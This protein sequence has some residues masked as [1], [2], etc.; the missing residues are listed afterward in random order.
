MRGKQ[1]SR[2]ACRNLSANQRS[3][4][5]R[6]ADLTPFKIGISEQ[7][8]TALALWMAKDAGCYAAGGLDAEIV[9]MGGGSRGAAAL[10]AG[11]I[12]AMHVGLSS[13]VRVNQASDDLRIIAALANVIR[14]TLFSAPDM[15][16]TASLKGGAIGISTFGSESESVAVLALRRLGLSRADVVLK[17]LGGGGR[18]LEALQY[19]SIKATALNEPVATLA[20]ERGLRVMLDLVPERIPWLFTGIVVTRAAIASRRDLLTRFLSATQEG[21][22]IALTD[23]ERAKAVLAKEAGIADRRVLDIAYEDFRALSPPDLAPTEA[24]AAN[25]LAHLP[26]AGRDPGAYIDGGI[27]K[28][29][30]R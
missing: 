29:L 23:P 28:M 10:A 27:L 24:A 13:V 1:S 3:R 25:V 22:R 15:T 5:V 12:D 19:G 14:F 26:G 6:S 2:I 4:K 20:R 16:S 11:R 18:R 7:V 21:N 8:N 17:E 9:N 30:H